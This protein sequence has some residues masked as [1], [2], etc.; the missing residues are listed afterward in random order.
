MYKY[1]L[2]VLCCLYQCSPILTDTFT[3]QKTPTDVRSK[4]TEVTNELARHHIL[5]NFLEQKQPVPMGAA[6][7]N[8]TAEKAPKNNG[9]EIEVLPPAHQ[10]IDGAQLIK[11]A[12]IPHAPPN[13]TQ[14]AVTNTTNK[15]TQIDRKNDTKVTHTEAGTILVQQQFN[16]GK[17][18]GI[19]VDAESKPE[20][21]LTKPVQVITNATV[22]QTQAP[23]GK[24]AEPDAGKA[25]PPAGKTVPPAG[26][27]ADPLV[28][29]PEAAVKVPEPAIKP[30]ELVVKVPIPLTNVTETIAN[31][32]GKLT[33]TKQ[34]Q[35]TKIGNNA[36]S[37]DIVENNKHIKVTVT[38][39][40]TTTPAPPMVTN[41]THKTTTIHR[42]PH[43]Y[44]TATTANRQTTT[45]HRPTTHRHRK[46]TATTTPKV[47]KDSDAKISKKPKKPTVTF[48]VDDNKTLLQIPHFPRPKPTAKRVNKHNDDYVID[49]APPQQTRQRPPELPEPATELLL[50]NTGRNGHR[51][52]VILLIV[53][54]F[55]LPMI[56][57]LVNV[58]ARRMRNYWYTR[59]HYR[60]MDFLVDGMYNC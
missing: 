32:T 53:L 49:D 58:C 8:V 40:P 34:Q 36:V 41:R 35:P 7:I 52:Y 26:K 46:V 9:A 5:A 10:H 56:F 14:D 3:A 16:G 43:R 55:A 27:T 22:V 19:K 21:L 57:G 33:E 11:N 31:A 29:V 4:S 51:R 17:S 47:P 54:I 37:M 60:R 50:D 2:I 20:L 45:T 15:T 12:T 44:T 25:V 24:V 39:T 42:T 38:K 18:I 59:H 48:S 13:I 23:A 6:P 30:P 1:T 28:K